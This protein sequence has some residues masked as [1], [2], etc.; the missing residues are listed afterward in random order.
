VKTSGKDDSAG[1]PGKA[2]NAGTRHP[3]G[4]PA[5]EDILPFAPEGWT[6]FIRQ[7]GTDF[8][9]QVSIYNEVVSYLDASNVEGVLPELPGNRI[10]H[11]R[12]KWLPVHRVLSLDNIALGVCWLFWIKTDW[13]PMKPAASGLQVRH[14]MLELADVQ[15]CIKVMS[16]AAY[17]EHLEWEMDRSK[18]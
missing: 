14:R 15:A 4:F 3:T 9:A 5:E 2:G 16:P 1:A 6:N 7:L 11:N 8:I 17:A 10:G 12:I 18:H 13:E